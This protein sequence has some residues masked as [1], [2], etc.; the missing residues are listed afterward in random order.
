MD[1]AGH[2]AFIAIA[3]AD[4]AAISVAL[5]PVIASDAVLCVDGFVTYEQIAKAV[6]IPHVALKAARRTPR[7]HHINT[8]NAPTSRFRALMRP[9]CRPAPNNVAAS[10]RWHA[11][12]NDA[13]LVTRT[14]AMPSRQHVLLTPP[15][16]LCLKLITPNS[17]R[18]KR[19]QRRSA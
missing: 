9:F 17:P 1:H 8:V 13:D 15:R 12:R 3:D 11:A 4:Q 5:L 10:G 7:S 14:H 6:R 19:L 18:T 2:A 16:S